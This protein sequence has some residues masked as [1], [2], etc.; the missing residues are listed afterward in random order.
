M[1]QFRPIAVLFGLLAAMAMHDA[2]LAQDKPTETTG[3]A[4][5]I[6][7][8]IRSIRDAYVDQFRTYAETRNDPATGR[9]EIKIEVKRS[10]SL[11]R[12][13][14]C[15]DYLR[16]TADGP[17]PEIFEPERQL[18]FDGFET[19]IGAVAVAFSSFGWDGVAIRYQS[20]RSAEEIFG[21]WFEHWF[22]PEDER[23]DPKALLNGNIHNI[24]LADGMVSIDMGT[25]PPEAFHELIAAFEA[26]GVTRLA[27]GGDL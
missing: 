10:D 18:Y 24:V 13:L 21:P 4:M 9:T 12:R 16:K 15:V 5:S 23:L 11:F 2:A 3:I 7:S 6:D 19:D 26:A 22:D 14:I 25:A 1:R 27:I 8:M 17:R 20:P